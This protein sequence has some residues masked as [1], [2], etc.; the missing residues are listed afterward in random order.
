MAGPVSNNSFGTP[1]SANFGISGT[2]QHQGPN[3]GCSTSARSVDAISVDTTNDANT[4]TPQIFRPSLYTGVGGTSPDVAA[5]PTNNQ[6]W[7]NINFLD[8]LVNSL[9]GY[10]TSQNRYFNTF[11]GCTLGNNALGQNICNAPSNMG[12]PSN[13]QVTFVDGNVSG[14][15]GAGLLVVTGDLNVRGN[16]S[17]DG[18]ILVVGTGGF[19][20]NGGGNGQINGGMFIAHTADFNSQGTG[21]NMLTDLGQPAFSAPLFNWNGGGTNYMQ[22]DSCWA[23]VMNTNNSTGFHVLSFREVI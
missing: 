14:I 20:A 17:W 13:P 16:F 2:D 19:N 3:G 8:S 1:H 9:R 5:M 10:A 22:W 18:E 21:L 11:S 6:T 4:L 12:T 15:S 23:S 7:Q